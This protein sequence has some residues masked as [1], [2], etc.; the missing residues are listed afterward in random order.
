MKTFGTRCYSASDKATCAA[1]CL[2]GKGVSGGCA[3]CFGR[4]M[5]CAIKNCLAG[6]AKDAYGAACKSSVSRT[7]GSFNAQESSQED[8]GKDYFLLL[9]WSR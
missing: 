8:A 5:S 2:V 4:K 1:T 9:L 7:C 6:C 3:S